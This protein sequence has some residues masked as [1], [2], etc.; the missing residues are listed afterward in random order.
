MCGITIFFSKN[1]SDIIRKILDS[2]YNIQNRGYDS[3]GISYLS[4]NL[5]DWCIEKYAS[6]NS[7][8]GI[9]QLEEKISNIK[10]SIAIGHT[11]W[12]THGARSDINA[13][14]H[15]S[16]NKKIIVVHN[17]I[18]TN[19]NV[20]K[21]MLISK[22]YK[23]ISETD[24]E[25]ISNLLE[26]E[27]SITKNIY[28]AIININKKLEGTWALGI[29]NTEERDKIYITR[30][31]SPLL[32]GENN[33]EIIC[34]S[35]ISGFI[36][37]INNYI[38]LNNDDII[39][40]DQNGYHTEREYN[41]NKINNISYETT[42]DPYKY[43]TLKEI[44]EQPKSINNAINNGGRIKDN[45]IVL[46]GL[47]YL[48]NYKNSI[49]NIIVLGCGTSYHAA[50]LFKYYMQNNKKFNIVT[51]Y[52]ASEFTELD[53]PNKGKT[54]FIVCSQ[55]GETRDLINML[56]IC[57][58][59]DSITIGVIN[60]VDSMLAKMV[61]CGVYLNAGLEKAV[62]STKSYTSM[63]IVLSLIA[64]WFNQNNNLMINNLR[65]ISTTVSDILENDHIKNDCLN[66]VN[67]TNRNKIENMFILGSGKLFSVA[68]E[69]ALKI[70]EISYIRAEG[71]SAGALKH[72]PFALLDSKTIVILLIDADNIEKLTS[73]YHE[74]TARETNCFVI[75]DVETDLFKNKIVIPNVKYYNEI[76]FAIILQYIAYHLS[77]TR[78]INPDRPRNLAKVV[79]VE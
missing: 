27:L 50:M 40:V 34:C 70:K 59:Y 62:A 71:Y 60:V 79:T 24:T 41:I 77:V 73:T 57:K 78:D 37:Q 29:I 35:E 4:D 47:N 2:L 44:Y 61:D 31:G 30:H 5:R 54:L 18:I 43:W 76:L 9:K 64:M 58:K 20:I 65:N 75:T 14:P 25:V 45:D 49:D 56:E 42:P 13:H 32:I 3:I 21:D 39:I 46:G 22:G 17:G 74:I 69:G 1:R 19:F 38:V 16:M 7:K 48:Q 8:D 55:S 53:I 12:A 15:I 28:T 72:G 63:L 23:F 51:A 66:L 10:S 67:F 6:T 33:K 26:D 68:K 52:D 11:R 36:G